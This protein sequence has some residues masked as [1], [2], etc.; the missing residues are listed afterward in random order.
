[1][2]ECVPPCGSDH[3]RCHATQY[4]RRL[5]LLASMRAQSSEGSVHRSSLAYVKALQD[6]VYQVWVDELP[7]NDD[8]GHN[9]LG[10]EVNAC[11]LACEV[12]E[13]QPRGAIAQQRAMDDGR[14]GCIYPRQ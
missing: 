3:V 1:M 11:C 7:G 10:A 8:V 14:L 12:P 13:V 9:R 6:L 5:E 2:S 4:A